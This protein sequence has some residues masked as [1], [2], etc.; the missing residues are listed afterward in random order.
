VLQR[1]VDIKIYTITLSPEDEGGML[2]RNVGMY[3]QVRMVL[4]R[5]RLIPTKTST[6]PCVFMAGKEPAKLAYIS[7]LSYI[8]IIFPIICI[9]SFIIFCL[10]FVVFLFSTALY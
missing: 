5:R 2:L 8:I 10:T 7:L 4:Q 9:I 1:R 6:S 3:V